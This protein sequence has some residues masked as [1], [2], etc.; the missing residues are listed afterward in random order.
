MTNR[1]R[2]IYADPPWDF[3]T[4]S[5]KGTGR[6]AVSHFDTMSLKELQALSISDF[7][8]KDCALLLWVTR[9]LPSRAIAD[10]LDSWGFVEKGTAFTWVKTTKDGK[11]FPIGN[12]YSTRANPERCLLATRGKPKVLAHNVPELIIALRQQYARKPVVVYEYIERLYA[13]P[14]IELFSRNTRPGWASWGKEV[15]LF[16]KG[17][18]KTRRQPSDL[19]GL[20]T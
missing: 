3:K 16:D 18:V 5:A 11:R 20:R 1:F 13:G 10:L 17:P 14:Y 15:G 7:A 4:F 19:T 2:V 8:A 6:S 12:G 9:W